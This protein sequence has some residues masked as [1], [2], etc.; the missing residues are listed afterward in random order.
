M[1]DITNL[2]TNGSTYFKISVVAVA[3]VVDVGA[4]VGVVSVV[5]AVD[6]DVAVGTLGVVTAVVAVT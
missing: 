5:H 4:V 1:P 6:G 2:A 3:V